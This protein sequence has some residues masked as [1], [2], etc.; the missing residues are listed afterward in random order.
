MFKSFVGLRVWNRD[1]EGVEERRMGEI[2][3]G[4]SIE[5]G[6][7]RLKTIGNRVFKVV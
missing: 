7:Q 1:L 5:L 2:I 6:V 3:R 4:K